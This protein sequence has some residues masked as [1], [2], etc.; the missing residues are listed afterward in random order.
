MSSQC[1]SCQAPVVW[2]T[3]E[4]GKPMPVDA[5]AHPDGNVLLRTRDGA[6]QA[7]VLGPLER[8]EQERVHRLHMAHHATCPDA[9][10]WRRS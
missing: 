9:D 8:I 4:N 1:R 10:T 7:V 2:A 3:T 6:W 5:D